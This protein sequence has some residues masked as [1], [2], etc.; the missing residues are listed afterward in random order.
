MRPDGSNPRRHI[1][2]FKETKRERFL[3]AAELTRLD[4][5]LSV[6]EITGTEPPSVIAAFR[7][8]LLTGCRLGEIQTLKW[9]YV[10]GSGLLLPDSKTGAKTVPIGQPVLD[11][12]TS[13]RRESG[14]PYVIVGKHPGSHLTDLQRSWRRI[15][16]RAGLPD[17]RIHDLRHSF[18]STA[19]GL[20]ESLPVIGKLLG[21]SQVQTTARYAHL[22]HDPV[23]SAADRISA[24]IA[25][26]LRTT[27]P[28]GVS[29][30]ATRHGPLG[31]IAETAEQ[32]FSKDDVKV[33]AQ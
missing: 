26:A 12:L 3:T 30:E 17:V 4:Q 23:R 13:L 9:D 31:P 6:A 28:A 15:R 11:V 19:V 27:E 10:Q 7:L 16:A 33:A 22:A 24:D 2:K 14:N 20:G 21:H 1:E 18:A 25:R 5:V 29:T 8:L 32:V